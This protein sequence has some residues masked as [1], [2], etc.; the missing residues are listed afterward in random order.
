MNNIKNSSF[1]DIKLNIIRDEYWDFILARDG[2]DGLFLPNGIN[3]DCL[4][5][6]ID[7]NNSIVGDKLYS[8]DSYLW[9]GAVNDGVELYNIGFTGIDNGLISYQKDRISNEQFY[10]IFTNSRYNINKGD[11]RFYLTKV[12]GNTQEYSYPIDIVTE[13]NSTYVK[14]TGGFYQGFFKLDGEKYQ[15]LPDVFE[16]DVHMEFV[17]RKQNYDEPNNTLNKTHPNNKG[18]FFYIGTR[19]ENKFYQFYNNNG[20]GIETKE[21]E[22]V[23]HEYYNDEE[24]FISEANPILTDY[25]YGVEPEPDTFI[26][27]GVVEDGYIDDVCIINNCNFTI[28]EYVSWDEPCCCQDDCCCGKDNIK[29]CQEEKPQKSVPDR[30]V[31]LN[32]YGYATSNACPPSCCVCGTKKI[33]KP[34]CNKPKINTCGKCGEES[35]IRKNTCHDNSKPEPSKCACGNGMTSI[36][37]AYPNPYWMAH[38]K[39]DYCQEEECGCT[40]SC[41]ND[42]FGDAYYD[43]CNKGCCEDDSKY[44][45]ENDYFQEEMSLSDIILNT[46]DGLEINKHG[47]YEIKSDNKYLFFNR[48]KTGYTT[49]TWSDDIDLVFRGIN[50]KPKDNYF[51][52]FNRTATGYTTKTINEYLNK[53]GIEEYDIYKDLYRN[54]FALKVNDDGSVS[55][56]YLVRN[57]ETEEGFDILTEQSNPGLIKDGEWCTINVRFSIIGGVDNCGNPLGERKMKLYIYVNGYLKLISKELPEFKFRALNDTPEKQETVPYNISLGGGTQGLADEVWINYYNKTNKILPLEKNFAGTFI[58]DFKSFKMYNCF[59]TYPTIK[60]NVKYN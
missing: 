17:I 4:I 16:S 36:I 51:L 59:Q 39:T 53:Y 19:A 42:Y 57:C 20:N 33:T 21:I 7:T 25:F 38:Y 50:Y 44:L 5:S 32:V 8:I 9:D 40:N 52:L 46:Y 6:Y 55:Y 26:N 43:P 37:T 12:T 48:T 35:Y 47:Y 18:I 11:N 45:I 60:N 58:G 13:N 34:N 54:A 3:T 1:K 24:Y 31:W 15:T 27:R 23:D 49:N 10:N 41:K 2:A 30:N 14:L 29:T 22:Y 28:G 56:H